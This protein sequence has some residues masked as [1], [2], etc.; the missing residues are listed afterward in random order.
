MAA[1]GQSA[2]RPTDKADDFIYR[3]GC[4]SNVQMETQLGGVTFLKIDVA[5]MGK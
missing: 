2:G 3:D 4:Q 5:K 1:N